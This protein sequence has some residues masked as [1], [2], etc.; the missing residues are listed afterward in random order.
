MHFLK[1]YKFELFF[2]LS[3][4]IIYFISRF[5]HILT[6]P[7]FT[8]EAIYVRWAQIAKN[9]ATWRF[10]S[11]TDGKQPMFVWMAMITMRLMKDPLFAS[12]AVSVFAGF[13]TVIGLFFL[14][15]E[16]FKNR[17]IG[18]LSSFL[19]VL[20]PFG[21]VYDRMALYDSLVATFCVWGLYVA[22]FLVRRVR[23]DVALIAGLVIGGGVLNKSSGFF[24]V[25]F[26]PAT[27]VLFDY[28]KKE[29]MRRLM[30]WALLAVLTIILVYLYYSIL[31]LSPYFH[32]IAEKDTTFI[33]PFREWIHHP[34][35]FFYG[36][37]KGLLDWF[38]TYVTYPVI[39]L[40]IGSIFISQRF[41]K[42][43]SLLIFWFV[44]PFVAAALFGKVLYPRYILL[45]TMSLIPLA[46]YTLYELG[47]RTKL[48]IAIALGILCLMLYIRADYF[49]L[50]D[51]AHAPIP[52]SDVTQF[53]NDW[54]AGGGVKETVAFFT[55]QSQ[56]KKIVI[57]TEGTYGLMPEA[58]EIS[59]VDNPNIKIQ[60]LWPIESTFPKMLEESSKKYPTYVVFYQPCVS[61]SN[62]DQ[63]PIGWPL[64]LIASYKKG[65]GDRY[66]RLY[67]V[68]S[69]K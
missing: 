5:Y 8:D 34:F 6:L 10:I 39:A 65:S 2:F 40:I 24:T 1:K 69:L 51:F 15:R 66:L 45:M 48:W 62:G 59:L 54:P 35:T 47:K 9:D 26:L 55:E 27:L 12:R 16:V 25:Y 67:Q 18:L 29:R 31:R 60:G 56:N 21:L 32:I 19:Y 42:E 57:A 28:S 11:L 14:G 46:A 33:Y 64:K 38:V 7:I 23:L 50:T 3:L 63:A 36:N 61:C 20:Y 58:Y 43:K 52:Q 53:V 41:F 22:I 68:I 44:A 30:K 17:W 49:I 13:G 4:T 37:L